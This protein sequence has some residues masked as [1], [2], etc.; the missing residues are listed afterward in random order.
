MIQCKERKRKRKQERKRS[1]RREEEKKTG[2]T[3]GHSML[4][5]ME[6]NKFKKIKKF[7]PINLQ[8]SKLWFVM[9][10]RVDESMFAQVLKDIQ[11]QVFKPSEY[12]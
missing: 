8:F 3:G 4:L 10:S 7:I 11:P 12:L 5:I 6:S 2:A 9:S 1:E